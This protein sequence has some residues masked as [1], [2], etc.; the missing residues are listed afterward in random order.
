MDD[1]YAISKNK[2]IIIVAHRISTVSQCDIVYQVENGA[3]TPI[4]L[5]EYTASHNHGNTTQHLP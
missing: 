5:Q 1:L 3:M 4:S 2:T